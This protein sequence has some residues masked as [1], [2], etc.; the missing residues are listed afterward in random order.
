MLSLSAMRRVL[1]ML[2]ILVIIRADLQ[3]QVSRGAPPPL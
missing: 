3:A 1:H 2:L